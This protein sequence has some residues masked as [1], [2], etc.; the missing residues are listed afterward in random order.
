M[1]KIVV[2][3]YL[4]IKLLLIPNRELTFQHLDF[5]NIKRTRPYTLAKRLQ[6]GL[7]LIEFT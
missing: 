1:S 6:K 2:Q 3:T 7:N 4:F 5:L